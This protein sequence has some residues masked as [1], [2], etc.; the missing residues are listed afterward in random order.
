MDLIR[1]QHS[2]EDGK[3]FEE[4]HVSLTRTVALKFHWI[5]SFVEGFKKVCET[6]SNFTMELANV[7]V[8]SNDDKTRTFLGIGFENNTALENL[9]EDLNKLLKEYQLPSFYEVKI[10]YIQFNYISTK[11]RKGYNYLITHFESIYYYKII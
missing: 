9:T 11:E 1:T 7:K 8:Y 3:L 6:T 4:F 2:I 5:D 10:Y